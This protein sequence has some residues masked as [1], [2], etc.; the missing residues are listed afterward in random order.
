MFGKLLIVI[1]CAAL[2]AGFTPAAVRAD[3]DSTDLKAQITEIRQKLAELEKKLDESQKAQGEMKKAQEA[4]APTVTA[5]TKGSKLKIDGRIFAGVFSTGADGSSPNWS[6][7]IKD[8]KLRFTFTPSDRITVVNRLS[9]SGAK[10]GDFDYFYLDYKG[11]LNPT[12]IIRVGQRKVDV[13]Q[14][15]WVDNPVENMLV[16]NAVS[17]VAGYATGIAVLGRFNETK[18]S[19]LYELG[20]TNGVK[21]VMV[22]PTNDIPFNVK[23]G[24]PLPSNLFASFSYFDSGT[25]GAADKPA[26]SVGGLSSA[27]IATEWDRKLWELDVRYNYGETGI[28]P[29][30]PTGDLPPVMLGATYGSF[31]DSAVGTDRDGKYWFLEGLVRMSNRT[32]AAARYSVVAL[33]DGMVAK[34]G[35]NTVDV[36]SY[37]RIS[38]GLGYAL[39]S[40][41]H[42]KAEYSINDTSG[43][44]S[45]PSLNQF[46][47]GVASKF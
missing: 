35:G 6:T 34:L 11:A 17:S 1:C 47:V 19:P 16:S 41:T 27:P 30:I 7:D 26:I 24:V 12:N 40:L 5:A 37:R 23:L 15:T 18:H 10:N 25:I 13:G 21:G 39:T 46:A 22:R 33:D 42:L 36:N 3:S 38:I 8:A 2:I 9:T 4:A 29:L 14:E 32:Y 28:R 31:S 43:G 44:A 20:F 45:D